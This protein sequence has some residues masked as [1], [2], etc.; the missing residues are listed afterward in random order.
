MMF[1][2]MHVREEENLSELSR[3]FCLENISSFSD[4]FMLRY[5][6]GNMIVDPIGFVRL[7]VILELV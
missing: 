2:P 5:V 6:L 7:L 3:I 4:Y 1:V